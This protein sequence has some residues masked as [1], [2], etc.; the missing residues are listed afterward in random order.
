[1]IQDEEDIAMANRIRG[2]IPVY[3]HWKYEADKNLAERTA[4]KWTMLRPGG[5]NNQPGTGNGSIGRTHLKPTIS[6]S[7]NPTLTVD[8]LWF[9]I[10][11]GMMSRRSFLYWSSAKTLQA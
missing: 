6:V 1:M 5:L 11:R 7:A 2:V 10:F 3:M 8:G 4:F 9:D